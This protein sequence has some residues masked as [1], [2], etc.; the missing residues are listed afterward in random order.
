MF[1]QMSISPNEHL[2]ACADSAEKVIIFNLHTGDKTEVFQGATTIHCLDFTYDG[3]KLIV[4]DRSGYISI[5]DFERGEIRKLDSKIAYTYQIHHSRKQPQFWAVGF[6]KEEQVVE[7]WNSETGENIFSEQCEFSHSASS[8]QGED[9][10]A[11]GDIDREVWIFDTKSGSLIHKMEIGSATD[12][13]SFSPDDR[14][15]AT[16]HPDATI[17]IWDVDQHSSS[18][19]QCLKVLDVRMNSR[20]AKIGGARGLEKNV[21]WKVRGE[22]RQGTLLEFFAERGAVLDEEQKRMLARAR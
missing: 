17:R 6:G 5:V 11:V 22:Q 21:T 9:I 7:C 10:F 3:N 4:G 16:G 20:G 15:L 12:G 8:N 2:L 1:H 18:F 14:F 19:G 13:I